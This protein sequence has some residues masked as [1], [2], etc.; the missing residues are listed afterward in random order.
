[1]FSNEFLCFQL[2]Q[3]EY[4]ELSLLRLGLDETMSTVTADVAITV[5]KFAIH[6]CQFYV[7]VIVLIWK[8]YT[9]DNS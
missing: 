4:D 2:V 1:M 6:V 9:Q 5:Y 3:K 8:L 7:E